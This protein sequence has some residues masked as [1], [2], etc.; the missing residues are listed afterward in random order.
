[1]G[2]HVISI[3][4]E[5]KLPPDINDNGLQI[6]E[7]LVISVTDRESIGGI[8]YVNHSCNPNAGIR[9]QIFLV[10]MRDIAAGEEVTFDYAMTLYGHEGIPAYRMECHCQAADCRGI[11]TDNDWKIPE[12]QKRYHGYFQYYLQEII[13]RRFHP[14]TTGVI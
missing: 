1:M 10:A 12:L 3:Q 6:T 14:V 2:G 5:Q 7:D 4:D 8:N 13:D 11:I 9:G